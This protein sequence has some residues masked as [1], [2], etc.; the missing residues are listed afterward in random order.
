MQT[1]AYIGGQIRQARETHGWSISELARRFSVSHASMSRWE[2]GDQTIDFSDLER[3]AKLL[4]RPVQFFLPD[5]YVDPSGLSPDIAALVGRINSLPHGPVRD[6]LIAN[7]LEQIDTVS[8]ALRRE[9][10]SAAR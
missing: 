7:I 9:E 2:S 5:W 6:K 3:L 1:K 8:V 10:D 4:E